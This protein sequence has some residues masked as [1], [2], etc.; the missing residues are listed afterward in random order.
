LETVADIAVVGAGSAGC[1]LAAKLSEDSRIRVT[2]IEAGGEASS[3]RVS[4]PNQWPLLWDDAENWGYATT[5]Q[6]GF[7][8][9]GIPY[10]RGKVLGGT[11]AI[12]AMI[13]MRGDPKDFDHWRDLGN[14]GWGWS[15]VLPY[16]IR[17]E[18][19]TL[20]ASALHGVGG[21]LTISAQAA[22]SDITMAFIEAAQACGHRHNIDFN[23]EFLDGAGLYH[24]TIRDGQRCSTAMAYLQPALHRPNLR[25][26][27]KA[28]ALR[29]HFEGDRAVAVDIWD[30]AQLRRIAAHQEVIL[31]AGAIDTPK[32]LML[33]GVG[34]PAALQPHGIAVKHA[35]PAVGQHLCDHVQTPSVFALKQ[36]VATAATSILAEGGLFMKRATAADEFG[37]HLQFFAFPQ[38]PLPA[39]ARGATPVMAIAAQ[40]CRPSSRGQVRLRS[41]DPLDPP[42]INPGYLTHPD[43][44]ALQIEGV[45]MARRIA[46]AEPLAS[47]LHGEVSPG[48]QAT[49]DAALEAVIRATSG[50]VWHPVGTCRMGP[51]KDAVVDAQLQVHGLR[52][53][54]GLRVVDASVMPQIT[55]ANTNLPT[56]MIAEKAADLVVG[57]SVSARSDGARTA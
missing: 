24:T 48:A 50:S 44:L 2:L 13:A 37:A 8:F 7:G 47:L 12:N 4:Q 39:A 9:R 3:P 16:F 30:G 49:S 40:A 56:V 29:V 19:H 53:L 34:D 18:D 17:S 32:L 42:V 33:S 54:R 57:R 46:A 10:P 1:V 23:G 43:D 5:L 21:P 15:D 14:S 31:C 28:R 41:S 20:A 6:A 45:R 55:S 11:G 22:P 36:P 27:P 35:L 38:V 51:G 25:I 26:I 52:G